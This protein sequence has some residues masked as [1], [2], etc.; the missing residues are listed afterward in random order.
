MEPEV[1]LSV[2]LNQSMMLVENWFWFDKND[3]DENTALGA[4]NDFQ[5]VAQVNS[6]YTLRFRPDWRCVAS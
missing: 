1:G 5:E 2:S 3:N 4:R 6:D